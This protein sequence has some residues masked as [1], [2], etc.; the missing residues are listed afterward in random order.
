MISKIMENLNLA[1]IIDAFSEEKAVLW[2]KVFPYKKLLY[3]FFKRFYFYEPI[4]MVTMVSNAC[5]YVVIVPAINFEDAVNRW[6]DGMNLS[7]EDKIA[8]KKTILYNSK[9]LKSLI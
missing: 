8:E 5:Q 1:S 9:T 6:I 3:V 2:E 4:V 7:E